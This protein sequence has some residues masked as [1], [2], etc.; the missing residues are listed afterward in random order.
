[1]QVFLFAPGVLTSL[2]VVPKTFLTVVG[3]INLW[4]HRAV[5]RQITLHIV[6]HH[7]KLLLP[8]FIGLLCGVALYLAAKGYWVP[9]S[10]TNIITAVFA[11]DHQITI[12]SKLLL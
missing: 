3:P 1:M 4:D 2:S 6:L 11:V 8:P 5:F 9:P 10:L 12:D 7:Q